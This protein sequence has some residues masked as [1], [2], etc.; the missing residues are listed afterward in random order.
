MVSC[1]ISMFGFR[2]YLLENDCYAS[3]ASVLI[4]I[5]Y[6][7]V[8]RSRQLLR[9]KGT[10]LNLI[11]GGGGGHYRFLSCCTCAKTVG[12]RQMKL[13]DFKYN[14]KGCHFKKLSVES[15]LRY[16]IGNAFVKERLVEIVRFLPKNDLCFTQMILILVVLSLKFEISDSKLV[17]VPNFSQ[18]KQIIREVE[19]RPGNCLMHHS[20]LM[21]MMS[22]T[23]L[24]AWRDFVSRRF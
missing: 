4:Q 5:Q 18:I 19:F 8:Y 1:C 22:G 21:I 15:N 20:Y 11:E 9:C 12:S 10:R 24:W 3:L 23:W 6:G 2:G 16:S 14:Y 13:C 17:P 7:S